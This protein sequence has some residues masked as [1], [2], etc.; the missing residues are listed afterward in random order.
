MTQ[1]SDVQ[2]ANAGASITLGGL[3]SLPIGQGRCFRLG[4]MRVAVFRQRDGSIYALDSA[5]PHAGGPL[6][7]GLVGDGFVVCPLHA[8]R[9]R[10]SDGQGIG[11]D[12]AI[13]TYPIEIKDGWIFL[14]LP[15][16]PTASG[17]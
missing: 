1:V 3:D 4:E 16:K 2:P 15:D 10:L 12:L 17:V 13:R 11:T 8:Y 9:F 6:S 7:D 5:C 14:R